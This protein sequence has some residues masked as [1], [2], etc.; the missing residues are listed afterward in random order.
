MTRYLARKFLRQWDV[1]ADFTHGL[2][3]AERLA[4][5]LTDVAIGKVL[6]RQAE[7]F[8]ERRPLA[9]RFLKKMLLRVESVTRE[10]ESSDDSVFEAIASKQAQAESA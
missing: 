10:I 6:V 4:R 5:I 2:L 7:R 3:H 8:P 9:A 1:K